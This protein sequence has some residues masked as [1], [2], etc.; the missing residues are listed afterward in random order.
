[1]AHG[2]LTGTAP[3][4]TYTPDPGFLGLD[5]FTFTTSDGH[6]AS[7]PATVDVTVV[8]PTPAPPPSGGTPPSSGATG[9][10][11]PAG[12]APAAAPSAQ[13]PSGTPLS[14]APAR[15]NRPP[16]L[17]LPV[18]GTLGIR[19][20]GKGWIVTGALSLDQPATLR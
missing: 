8:P 16:R 19:R 5:S 18:G 10:G 17:T 15:T 7:A 20:A 13:Q 9:S 1:P 2:T 4:L 12:G 3:N 6:V 14:G 11:A